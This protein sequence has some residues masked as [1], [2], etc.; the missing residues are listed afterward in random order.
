MRLTEK[1]ESLNNKSIDWLSQDQI[2]YSFLLRVP[3]IRV[4][5]TAIPHIHAFPKA[6]VTMFFATAWLQNISTPYASE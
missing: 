4:Y 6:A 2:G 5:F 3:R 1:E